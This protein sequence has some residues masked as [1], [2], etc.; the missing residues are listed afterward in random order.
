[1]VTDGWSVGAFYIFYCSITQ[2]SSEPT[3]SENQGE[4]Y[5]SRYRFRQNQVT[6]LVF[7]CDI[8]LDIHV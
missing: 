7:E 4:T 1:M 5:I 6:P 8:T 3:E 2:L